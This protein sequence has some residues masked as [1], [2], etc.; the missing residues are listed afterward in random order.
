[1][2]TINHITTLKNENHNDKRGGGGKHLQK[3][4]K[5]KESYKTVAI[6]NCTK[7]IDVD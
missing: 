5:K 2:H 1:M 6:K 7:L 3:K 4:K